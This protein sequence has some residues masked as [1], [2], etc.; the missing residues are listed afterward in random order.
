MIKGSV[1]RVYDDNSNR[2]Y[3]CWLPARTRVLISGGGDARWRLANVRGAY[4]AVVLQHSRA[5]RSVI[6]WAKLG[7][8][9][10]H[11]IVYTFPRQE[12][13]P[14]LQLYVSK[15]GA[16]AFSRATTIGYIAPFE[17]GS[18]PRYRMLDSG[19]RVSGRSLWADERAGRLRWR[20]GAA[21][22]SAPWR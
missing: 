22:K 4:V 8:R 5:R 14:A 20:N 18:P 7:R 13:P 3:A 2:V 16:V 11:R 21:K 17:P 19:P 6:V 12:N 9:P 15:R 10:A 1:S